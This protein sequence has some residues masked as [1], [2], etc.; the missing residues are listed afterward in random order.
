MKIKYLPL[1]MA[2]IICIVSCPAHGQ[3]INTKN[4]WKLQSTL[5]SICAEGYNLFIAESVNW[6]STDSVLAHYNEDSLGGSVIWQPTDSTWSAVFFDTKQKN[7]L[8]ELIYNVRCNKM[9][10]SYDMRPIS[11]AEHKQFELKKTMLKNAID[12]YGD[13]LLFNSECGQAN[14]DFVR[15]DKKTIRM[16]LLQ[17]TVHPNVIPFGNDYSI[18]F[19]NNGKAKCFRQYH[20]SLIAVNLDGNE[21]EDAI[22]YHSHLKDNPYITPTDVC[23]FLLYRGKMKQTYVLSTALDGYIIYDADKNKAFFLSTEA[24]KKINDHEHR[25]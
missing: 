1:I 11:Q 18:D 5:N 10:F 2:S 13:K 3:K 14:M 20:H 6:I 16:Y 19:D 4:A 15:I 25:K 23:N 17:G 22:T 24:M 9:S 7:C 21:S 8:F 12:K